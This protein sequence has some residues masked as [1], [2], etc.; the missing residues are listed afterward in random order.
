MSF[1]TNVP[2]E[3]AVFSGRTTSHGWIHA[4]AVGSLN[5]V[6][7]SPECRHI[8]NDKGTHR[9]INKEAFEN[10]RQESKEHTEIEEKG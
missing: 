8:I 6:L 2:L 3:S 10:G 9:K 4:F 7:I 1:P 5:D